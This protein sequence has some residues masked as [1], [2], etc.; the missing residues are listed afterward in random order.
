V[1][2]LTPTAVD[3]DWTAD[4]LV[5]GLLALPPPAAGRHPP[6]RQTLS[7]ALSALN[8][9]LDGGLASARSARG[10]RFATP[11]APRRRRRR[12][13]A[14]TPSAP[15]GLVGWGAPPD[16]ACTAWTRRRW[17][18]RVPWGRPPPRQATSV[19]AAVVAVWVPDAAGTAGGLS[20]GATSATWTNRRFRGSAPAATDG[21]GDD[22]DG[23]DD[24][25]DGAPAKRR[26]LLLLDARTEAEVEAAVAATADAVGRGVVIAHQLVRGPSSAVTPAVLAAVASTVAGMGDGWRLV[27]KDAAFMATTVMGALG[28]VAA[29]GGAP[30][31]FIHL[32]WS[33]PG[34]AGVDGA[35]ALVGEGVTYDAGGSNLK[36][37]A[38]RMLG[39]MKARWWG[40]VRREGCGG[41]RVSARV[42]VSQRGGRL[43][44]RGQTSRWRP[45][46]TVS[47]AQTASTWARNGRWRRFHS[48]TATR[49]R[50]TLVSP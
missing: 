8:D 16:A 33:P 24:A 7:A 3:G 13:R 15:C 37:G 44:D 31:R 21:D 6:P 38:E 42:L 28:A 11:R 32:A 48:P 12:C 36:T 4:R 47:P 20:T 49:P 14:P 18:S 45:G 27:V 43:W 17:A 1:V 29:G 41:R 39:L 5:V 26:E 30:P 40:V 22:G 34:V 23:G 10:P 35:I 19:G 50:H 9:R 25:D 46:R 2:T